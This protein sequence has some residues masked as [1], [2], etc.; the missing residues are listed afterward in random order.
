MLGSFLMS[1]LFDRV[2]VC[3]APKLIGGRDAKGPIGGKGF[4]RLTEAAS[5]EALQV[6]SRGV[7]RI[8]EGLREGSLA[9]LR[10]R[11]GVATVR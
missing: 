9:E 8:L 1:G 7:D 5:L 3:C 2:A 11:L 10:Q 4:R 6:R